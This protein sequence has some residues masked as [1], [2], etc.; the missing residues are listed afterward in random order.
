MSEFAA[1]IARVRMKKGG[2]DLHIIEG[3]QEPEEESSAATLVR[4]ARE[5]ADVGVAGFILLGFDNEGQVLF[6][7]R[8]D[9]DLP[10]PRTLLPT[11]VAELVRR[12]VLT[13]TQARV[14]FDDMFKWV[15]G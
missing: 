8:T 12:Y 11:Y 2:A 9:G 6:Q 4:S 13:D 10:I 14:V 5:Y 1:R 3:W 15:E 7:H